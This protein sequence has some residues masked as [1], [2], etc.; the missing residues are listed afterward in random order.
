MRQLRRNNCVYR[1]IFHENKNKS[2]FLNMFAKFAIK[3]LQLEYFV[4]MFYD[5]IVYLIMTFSEEF[6]RR[7]DTGKVLDFN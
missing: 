7:K 4:Y 6:G 5:K 3:I 2:I 1:F